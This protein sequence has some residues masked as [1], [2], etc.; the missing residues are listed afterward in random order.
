M[1]EIFYERE[2]EEK[3]GEQEHKHMKRIIKNRIK[4]QKKEN[5]CYEILFSK[6]ISNKFHSNRFFKE[7]DQKLRFKNQKKESNLGVTSHMYDQKK[8]SSLQE[9]ISSVAM[10][11]E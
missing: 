9:K 1:H 11:N 7:V 10:F 2:I 4:E 6:K 3:N 5:F 8:L